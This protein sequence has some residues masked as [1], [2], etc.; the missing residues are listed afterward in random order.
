MIHHRY[1]KKHH[2]YAHVVFQHGGDASLVQTHAEVAGNWTQL[3]PPSASKTTFLNSARTPKLVATVI[4]GCGN[5][6][7]RT[8]F[9]R[10]WCG[11]CT[12][13]LKSMHAPGR[14]SRAQAAQRRPPRF[15][16]LLSAVFI[17]HISQ[18]NFVKHIIN[19]GRCFLKIYGI[20][21]FHRVGGWAKL[22]HV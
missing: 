22:E 4:H 10:M 20:R 6:K 12:L 21:K 7:P 9:P 17:Q 3:W 1:S 8:Y 2:K 19:S 13:R 14:N 11:N 16:Y 5:C 15:I 18:I